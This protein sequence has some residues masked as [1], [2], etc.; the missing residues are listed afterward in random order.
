MEE[1]CTGIAPRLILG[2]VFSSMG[3]QV[4]L[5]VEQMG[6][7]RLYNRRYVEETV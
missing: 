2:G 4:G 5:L 1:K 3:D 6:L 7:A